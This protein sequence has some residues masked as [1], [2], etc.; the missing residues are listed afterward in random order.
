MH[1]ALGLVPLRIGGTTTGTAR[2]AGVSAAAGTVLLGMAL[3]FGASLVEAD[4]TSLTIDGDCTGGGYSYDYPPPNVG[5]YNLYTNTG[6][7]RLAQRSWQ[8][9]GGA[10]QT[11]EWVQD[12]INLHWDNYS[13]IA[14]RGKHRLIEG[15]SSTGSP[16]TCSMGPGNCGAW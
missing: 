14:S 5:T 11:H 8:V 6:C 9:P 3:A 15:F 7:L 1:I 16:S 13:A 12:D 2:W 10:W 4:S